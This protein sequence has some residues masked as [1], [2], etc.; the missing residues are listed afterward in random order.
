ML[1]KMWKKL[2]LAVCI[3]AILFNVTYK[4]VNRT[5]LIEELKSVIGGEVISLT[6]EKEDTNNV[7]EK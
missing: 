2:L 6:E 1:A 5:N 4:I 7:E 3:I